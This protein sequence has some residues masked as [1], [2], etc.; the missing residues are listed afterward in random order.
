[1]DVCTVSSKVP[2]QNSDSCQKTSKG[3]IP[4]IYKGLYNMA[5]TS[6]GRQHSPSTPYIFC[7]MLDPRGTQVSLPMPSQPKSW[8][9]YRQYVYP[10]RSYFLVGAY[11][12]QGPSPVEF[13]RRPLVDNFRSSVAVSPV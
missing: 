4:F 2:R 9:I 6:V 5:G 10:L 7:T 12:A 3:L 1:M 13:R 8:D 11:A